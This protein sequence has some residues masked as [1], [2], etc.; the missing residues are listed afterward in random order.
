MWGPIT[1]KFCEVTAWLTHQQLS[2]G[3][4]TQPGTMMGLAPAGDW[5]KV[6]SGRAPIASHVS[7]FSPDPHEKRSREEPQ[8]GSGASCH[9]CW[10]KSHFLVVLWAI[11]FALSSQQ[12]DHGDQHRVPPWNLIVSKKN[13]CSH[14]GTFE[15]TSFPFSSKT[16]LVS[17]GRFLLRHPRVQSWTPEIHCSLWMPGTGMILIQLSP[18]NMRFAQPR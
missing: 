18:E 3:V 8:R 14:Y 11:I 16:T 4:E 12:R 2:L 9:W 5:F 7:H 6:W 17:S 13:T 10:R 15:I 1:P